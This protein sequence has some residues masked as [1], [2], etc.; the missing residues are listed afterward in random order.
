MIPLRSLSRRRAEAGRT[1]ELAEDVLVA[2]AAGSVPGR[3]Q[4][5]PL[6]RGRELQQ[7]IRDGSRRSDARVEYRE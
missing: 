7:G 1:A 2:V 6:A 4:M 3:L 5:H